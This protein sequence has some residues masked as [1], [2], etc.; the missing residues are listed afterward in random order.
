MNKAD[1]TEQDAELATRYGAYAS[2]ATPHDPVLTETHGDG[3]AEEMDR[4]LDRFTSPDSTVL[5][6]GCGAGQT[7]CRLAPRCRAVWGID[8]EEPLLRA[9]E[10]RVQANGISNATLILG[11]TTHTETVARLPDGVFDLVFSRR[12]P[13]LTH[14]LMPKL[15][16]DTRFVV[17]LAQDAP[18]LK[19]IFGRRPFLPSDDFGDSFSWCIGHHKGL[20]LLPVSVR[21]FY[22]EQYFR[23]TEHLAAF[24]SAGSYLSSWWM[25]PKP[26]DPVQDR[27]A[28]SLYARYNSTGKGIRLIQHRKIFVFRRAETNY[29]P[30]DGFS[31]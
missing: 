4:L 22:F 25:P 6:L 14:D 21:S 29:Y 27:E 31:E 26:F 17:E 20:G 3:P 11:D 9:A 24:L 23:D 28:L 16:P 19:E 1:S 8:L 2:F 13:F 12:G 15:T 18:G 5:D 10:R 30:A 7:L